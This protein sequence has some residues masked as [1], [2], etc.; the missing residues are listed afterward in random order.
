MGQEGQGEA[1]R[2]CFP[3]KSSITTGKGGAL[4]KRVWQLRR[5]QVG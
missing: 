5:E 4:G 2:L 3:L 1:Q